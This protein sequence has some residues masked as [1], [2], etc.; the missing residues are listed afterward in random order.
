MKNQSLRQRYRQELRRVILESAREAFVQDGYES[1]SMRSLAER[2]GCSHGSIY[3]HFKDKEELFDCLVEESFAQL[4]EVLAALKPEGK[5]IDPVELLRKAGR[6][7][8]DFGL[9][10]PGAYEFA[11]VLRRPGASHP[12]KPHLAYERLRSIMKQCID[13]KRFRRI[14]VDTAS[15]AVWTAVHGVTSLLIFRPHF[16]WASKEK[17]IAQVVD[18]AINGLLAEPARPARKTQR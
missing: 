7:Y 12:E 1:L 14:G 18:S 16:P 5:K 9:R 2:I 3:L 6:A 17:V 11:F 4:A 8:V 15:Q 10:N 13:E